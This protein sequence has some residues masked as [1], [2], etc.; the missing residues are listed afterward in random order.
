MYAH[1]VLVRDGALPIAFFGISVT[2]TLVHLHSD[3]NPTVWNLLQY[4]IS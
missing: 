2:A 4:Y 3:A 1:C